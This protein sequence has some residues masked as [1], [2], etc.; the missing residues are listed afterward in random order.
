MKLPRV[1]LAELCLLLMSACATPPRVAYDAQQDA[2]ATIPGIADARIWSDDPRRLSA[3]II[4]WQKA[5]PADLHAPTLLSLSGGGSAGA[6]GAG[7]LACWSKTGT[8]PKFTVV[9]GT[10][11]GALIAPFAFL[12][13]DYDPIVGAMF[14]AGVASGLLKSA[15]LGGL[16]GLGLFKTEPLK[17]LVDFY[18][19]QNMLAAIAREYRAGRRLLVVTTDLDNQR[20]AIWDMGAIAA[21]GSPN[22]L[23]LFRT[24]LVASA[25]IP[26][27]FP[28]QFIEVQA[29]GRYFA[30]MHVDGG[31][32]ANV[33]IIPESMLASSFPLGRHLQPRFYVIVNGKIDPAFSQVEGGLVNIVSRS[34]ETTVKSNTRT[35]LLAARDYVRRRG[36]SLYATAIPSDV[37]IADA[38]DFTTS[39]M[40]QLYNI[41]CNRALSDQ[42]WNG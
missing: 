34:F 23:R 31:V 40:Q 30:E 12:G 21:S 18:I 15:G 20:T 11:V 2:Q 14:T 22:A 8:R 29:Q 38:T 17:Q 27:V 39:S 28:P 13:S 4:E 26:G 5:S 6:Y 41:G 10:S 19:D 16:L 3:G 37:P 24:I 9:T 1:L 25:S 32:T 33:L 35:S 36:W 42:P 7:F